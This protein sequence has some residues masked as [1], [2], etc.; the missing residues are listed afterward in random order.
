MISAV[1]FGNKIKYVGVQVNLTL[2]RFST[3]YKTGKP[4]MD[5]WENFVSAKV[6]FWVPTYE[7]SS[8]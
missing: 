1:L 3:G 4:V 2:G 7:L 5:R 6:I 8:I